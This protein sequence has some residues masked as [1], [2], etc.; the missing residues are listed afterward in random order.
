MLMLLLHKE[1]LV[2]HGSRQ[3]EESLLPGIKTHVNSASG[4]SR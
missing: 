1:V 2:E 3:S 4:R